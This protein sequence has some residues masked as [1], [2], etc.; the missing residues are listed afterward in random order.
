MKI[1]A[2]TFYKRFEHASHDTTWWAMLG[3][4]DEME[5]TLLTTPSLDAI[6][7]YN[8]SIY[9]LDS[10]GVYHHV[11]YLVDNDVTDGNQSSDNDIWSKGG[12][13]LSITRIHLSNTINLYDQF[14]KIN[15]FLSAQSTQC[16]YSGVSWRIY[17][18]TELSDII[19]ISRAEKFQTLSRWSLLT[20]KSWLVGRAYTYFCIS[21]FLLTADQEQWPDTVKED[22]V[23]FLSVRF[24]VQGDGADQELIKVGQQ[25]G[26]QIGT[27][28]FRVAGNEDALISVQD[29]PM[30]NVLMLYHSW[31]KEPNQIR[32]IFRDIISRVGADWSK[33]PPKKDELGK[34]QPISPIEEHSKLLLQNVQTRISTDPG[35]E[36]HS[37]A[38]LRPLI[39]LTNSLVHMSR[40][41]TL[42]GA[43]FLVLPALQAFWKN[44]LDESDAF[45]EDALYLRFA[46]L[47]THTI[48]HLMRAEGQL[49]HRPEMRPLPFDLP[50]FMLE[51]A[52]TFLMMFGNKL[53]YADGV[54][55]DEIHFLLVP[56]ADV[57]VSTE[58]P[59]EAKN[60]RPGLLLI[61][62]PFSLLYQ[63]Q[64]LLPTLCHEM[65]HYI[66]EK[67]RRREDRYWYFLN[68]IATVFIDSFFDKI[69]NDANKFHEFI[70]REILD[71]SIR[72]SLEEKPYNGESDII[73]L[74]LVDI[75]DMIGDLVAGIVGEGN[76]SEYSKLVRTY[77][78][79]EY[80]GAKILCYP[81]EYIANQLLPFQKRT[82]DLV[83]SFRETFADICMLSCLNPKLTE[84]LDITVMQWGNMNAGTRLRVY[85]SLF[86]SGHTIE[87]IV[88]SIDIWGKEKKIDVESRTNIIEEFKELH[89]WIR[90]DGD[91]AEKYLI[92]YLTDCW[93]DIE[94]NSRLVDKATNPE[95]FTTADIYA[96]TKNINEKTA[97]KQIIDIIDQGRKI[98]LGLIK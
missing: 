57:L 17:H 40:T 43:V 16:E 78:L 32:T 7:E 2:L 20:T 49:S 42:D 89:T 62:V 12:S 33:T 65:A 98:V 14:K 53:S 11:V 92:S 35:A 9:K 64:Y 67:L 94:E 6:R 76:Y 3:H 39:E 87:E 66:G 56:S 72:M 41:P 90:S 13:Y 31:Y 29:V 60:K 91:L 10:A 86:S 79:S 30:E 95:N 23:D 54:N 77:I 24:S 48:E 75:Y 18:T 82:Y 21:G 45:H 74:P 97:Y 4:L 69:K 27:K 73:K 34:P 55:A 88:E 46:E 26:N 44:I 85:A 50:M 25:L 52:T 61:T 5:C 1:R 96:I 58:E 80:S 47:C 19:L 28:V 59:F 68:A 8:D 36:L 38:W 70:V 81:P 71:E 84:Y 15:L 93:K 51:C 22:M 37:R 63:P 83:M